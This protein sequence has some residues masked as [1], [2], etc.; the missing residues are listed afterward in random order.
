MKLY[1]VSFCGWKIDNMFVVASDPTK[2]YKKA[3]KYLDDND[4]YFDKDRELS[5]VTLLAEESKYPD[6]ETHLLL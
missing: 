6:C 3:R 2:A 4:W 1:E 5:T